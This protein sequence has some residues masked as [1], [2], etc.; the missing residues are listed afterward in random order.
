MKNHSRISEGPRLK[1]L[2]E[3]S[4]W[5]PW[6]VMAVVFVV[7]LPFGITRYVVEDE[8][9]YLYAAE[10]ILQ[11]KTP[12]VDFFYPQM[13]IFPYFYAAWMWLFGVGWF[14][15]RVF[16][17]LQCAGV[18][19][20]L[21]HWVR[22]ETN[23]LFWSIWAAVLFTFSSLTI[24]SF[25]T[26]RT[27]AITVVTAL[28]S[29]I[30]IT[31]NTEK[32]VW[33]KAGGAGFLAAVC[34]GCR[35]MMAPIIPLILLISLLR[36]SNHRWQRLGVCLVGLGLGLLPLAFF[37]FKDS[38]LFAF[39]NL[40]FHSYRH[41]EAGLISDFRQKAEIA[42]GMLGHTFA[43][44]GIGAQ[45]LLLTV[46][47]LGGLGRWRTWTVSELAV[48]IYGAISVVVALLPTPT[49]HAYFAVPLPF[50]IMAATLHLAH[51][52]RNFD[53]QSLTA[54]AGRKWVW[55]T[56]SLYIL[57]ATPDFVYCSYLYKHF[58]GEGGQNGTTFSY[59]TDCDPQKINE[60]SG[61]IR[62]KAGPEDSILSF[63]S[64]YLLGTGRQ[65]YP[66]T[67]SH[68]TFNHAPLLSRELSADMLHRYRL[69]NESDINLIIQ[70][71]RVAFIVT[72]FAENESSNTSWVRRYW[73]P[74]ISAAGYIAAYQV[75][76]TV[77]YSLPNRVAS[78]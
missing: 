78:K 64:G 74:I 22:R 73:E 13:P 60:V 23:S 47:V 75:G 55:L 21:F 11:G 17:I 38:A 77:I 8:G 4:H 71:Q 18:A 46:I 51:S 24:Y 65:P 39:N 5:G 35:L 49:F 62:R 56:F 67:E 70:Q 58:Q 27:F 45:F 36:K 37:Y 28:A 69:V 40:G 48:I 14:S 10:L 44:G 42:L 6:L 72:S 68:V 50:W 30:L 15:A 57:L 43:K 7:L 25:L 20:L 52:A 31:G 59:K 33:L 61:L 12:Y 3:K 9:Y 1:H 32:H 2:F 26:A 16:T 76:Q 41:T 34:F 53:E 54:A 66:N 29:L 19:A 63:W